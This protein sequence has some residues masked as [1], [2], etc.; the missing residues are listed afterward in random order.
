MEKEAKKTRKLLKKEKKLNEAKLQK[1]YYFRDF[2]IEMY[3]KRAQYFWSFLAVIYAG[4]F[5]LLTTND[6]ADNISIEL[7]LLICSIGIIMSFAW[8]LVNRG[9]KRWQEHWESMITTY[10][11]E[12]DFIVYGI[13]TE[14]EKGIFK[15]GEF[16]VSKINIIVSFLI[17]ISWLYLFFYSA[18]NFKDCISLTIAIVNIVLLIAI[19]LISRSQR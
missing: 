8:Y 19:C 1:A 3:W 10:E 12:C 16:S 5:L 4:Y 11:R 17:F 7:K 14:T 2:E 18:N 9:S 15:A 13:R 6:N